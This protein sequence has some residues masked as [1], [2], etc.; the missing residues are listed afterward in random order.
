MIG[1]LGTLRPVRLSWILF[2][3]SAVVVATVAAVIVVRWRIDDASPAVD[4]GSVVLLGDSIT[5]Q[6]DWAAVL[7]DLPIVNH[8]Y[9][10]YTTEQLVPVAAE[11]ASGGPRAVFVLTGTNDIRDGRNVEW[12]ASWLE[13]LLDELVGS[14]VDTTVVV[15]TVLPRGDAVDE[16]RAIN[17]AIVS[18]AESR[19][20]DVVDLYAAFDDG[21]GALRAAETTDGVHLS[22][23]GYARWSA[24]LAAAV[25]ELVGA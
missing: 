17:E 12:S 18:V 11:V 9:S 4:G 23:A 10:G 15:Q 2:G 5:A 13:S 8:G 3:G 1:R 21:S 16:V 22:P 19:G 6:G 25:D 14:P 24:I 20:V 7:P